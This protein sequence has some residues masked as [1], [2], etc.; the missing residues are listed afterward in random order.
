[1]FLD[2]PNGKRLMI[3]KSTF[4]WRGLRRTLRPT[5]PKSVPVAPAV[6]DPVELGIT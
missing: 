3:E 5:L 6:A 4:V 2:S 1:M